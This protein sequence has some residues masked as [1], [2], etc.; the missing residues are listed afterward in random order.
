MAWVQEI[1]ILNLGMIQLSIAYNFYSL[2]RR[3]HICRKQ[4]FFQNEP[5]QL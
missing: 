5:M 3:G 2:S 1:E 4:G